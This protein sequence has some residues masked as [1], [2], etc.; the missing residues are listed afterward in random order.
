MVRAAPA[1]EGARRQSPAGT[2]VRYLSRSRR[3]SSPRAVQ[4]AVGPLRHLCPRP[5]GSDRRRHRRLS[6]L[7]VLAGP[8]GAASGDRFVAAL[9]LADRRQA[10]RGDGRARRRS[11]RTAAAAIRSSPA[12]ASPARKPPPATTRAPSPSTTPSPQARRTP[13]PD[14]RPRHAPRGAHP[15]RDREPRRSADAHR[16]SRRRPAIPG[17]TPPARSSGSPPGGASD[18]ATAR[19]YFERDRRRP[20]NAAA[21][22]ATRAQFMLALITRAPGA[23]GRAQP[24]EAPKPQPEG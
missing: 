6:W 10:H 13:A 3:G 14:P 23:A 4:E 11:P 17:A 18:F 16:R 7:G 22:S 19:K 12:S 9:K 1:T 21:T 5:R 2:N 24:P 15:G 20:G 8:P